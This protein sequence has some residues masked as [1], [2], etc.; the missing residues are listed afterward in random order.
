MKISLILAMRRILL[1]MA[2]RALRQLGFFKL[3]VLP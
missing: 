1:S 2:R 3:Q